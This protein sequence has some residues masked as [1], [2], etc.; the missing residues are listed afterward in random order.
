V[1]QFT[2]L[3]LA[4]PIL[5]ALAEEG[6]TSP[7]PIQ[8]QAIPHILAGRDI[9]GAAQTGTGKTAAFALPLLHRLATA[10]TRPAPKSIRALILAP[11][12]EL[13]SQIEDSIKAYGRH[14]A[15]SSA[16]AF[17]GVPI[18]RQRRALL[19]GLHI[20]VATPGRLLDLVDQR[21]IDLSKV[22]YLVLDEADRMLDLGFIHAL[23]RISS[24]LP[25]DRQSLFF[26]ATMPPPIRD[27]AGRFLKSD[28]AEVAVA[29][30]A[31]A[32]ETVD[33]KV[34]MVRNDRKP[35]LLGRIL[36]EPG[37]D[38][39][40]VFTRTKHGADRVVRQL[41]SLG[42]ASAAIHGNKS[43]NQREKALE[44]FRSGSTPV[45]V[46]TDI[47][48]RG[49]DVDGVNL[50]V[51]YELPN[52]PE[53]YVH[54]IGRTGR[55][56]A[57]GR[58][59]A[60]CAGD[61]APFLRDIERLMRKRIFQEQEPAGLEILGNIKAP[62]QAKPAANNGRGQPSRNS[63]R[64]RQG[65]APGRQETRGRSD[66]RPPRQGERPMSDRPQTDRTGD[67]APSAGRG[68]DRTSQPRPTGEASSRRQSDSPVSFGKLVEMIGT[69]APRRAPRDP[70][71][72]QPVKQRPR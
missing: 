62:P 49:I 11:T 29:P 53:T 14:M 71:R 7:T 43:Q 50:V 38:R 5:K 9:V 23:K 1:T 12:R 66:A 61:E 32:A 3:G 15:V 58:A 8:A 22:E 16:T 56:G 54:R 47:A 63:D 70:Q 20:L 10:A 18:G 60:F 57:T 44:E 37:L 2:D 72:D 35:A 26:S 25:K 17:G 69:D 40:I 65:Q 30:V 64:P 31:S 13:A 33:Q 46:A 59:V 68:P 34:I 6:Y 39:V 67:R 19:N 48:A 55:A 27:L 4:S 45:L 36:A 24:L 42:I 28:P 51:N 41:G 21:D 52:V